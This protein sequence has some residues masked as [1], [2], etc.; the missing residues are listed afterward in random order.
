M[1]CSESDSKEELEV[2]PKSYDDD[3]N[4]SDFDQVSPLK[5]PELTA[6]VSNSNLYSCSSLE[7]FGEI[8]APP[9]EST[10]N[11]ESGENHD[12]FKEVIKML[13]T[14]ISNSNESLERNDNDDLDE[15]PTHGRES[16]VI[17][18][19][20]DEDAPPVLTFREDRFTNSFSPSPLARFGLRSGNKTTKSP[21]HNET[22]KKEEKLEKINKPDSDSSDKRNSIMN[23][24][25]FYEKINLK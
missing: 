19:E 14:F 18:K 17:I 22:K 15:T 25:S 21:L 20:E 16:S 11:D 12:E 1:N 6:A 9:D 2:S 23:R 3:D 5:N 10:E 4:I 13:D 24:I 8:N 7:S